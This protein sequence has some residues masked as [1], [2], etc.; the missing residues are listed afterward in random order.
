MK[1]LVNSA[2]GRVYSQL[3]TDIDRL[4]FVR[5]HAHEKTVH[6]SPQWRFYRDRDKGLN[7]HICTGSQE[8]RE[9]SELVGDSDEELEEG[10][11][12]DHAVRRYFREHAHGVEF[13]R[14][15]GRGPSSCGCKS[16]VFGFP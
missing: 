3:T 11:G 8:D 4:E 2:E 10:S 6:V 12:R 13:T 14:Q 7:Y 5:L 16:C 1:I 9:V 15:E